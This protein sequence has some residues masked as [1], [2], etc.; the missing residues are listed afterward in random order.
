MKS[1]HRWKPRAWPSRK[2]SLP[3]IRTA[4]VLPIGLILPLDF[5]TEFLD[6]TH[7]DPS[8][9]A[10]LTHFEALGLSWTLKRGGIAGLACA[11]AL[12]SA[13]V[14]EGENWVLLIAEAGCLGRHLHRS[15]GLYGEIT[16]T[17]AGELED[18]TDDGSAVLLKEGEVIF[19]APDTVHKPFVRAFWVGLVHQPGGAISCCS[20]GLSPACSN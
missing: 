14:V 1:S 7:V 15:G 2:A 18:Q 10:C 12:A 16:I 3:P 4:R 17:L 8:M 5:P 20:A 19:H 6:L 9:T 13:E 11:T